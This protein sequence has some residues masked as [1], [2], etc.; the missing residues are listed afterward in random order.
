[1]G[2]PRGWYKTIVAEVAEM[3]FDEDMA[4]AEIAAKLECG[5]HAVYKALRL[6]GRPLRSSGRR[7]AFDETEIALIK[8][9]YLELDWPSQMI[10][11]FFDVSDSTAR[12]ALTDNNVELRWFGYKTK[13][14][15]LPKEQ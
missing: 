15:P 1:M 14:K 11:D 12:R 13:P 9:M 4:V 2:K 6:D 3:Y 5:K 8:K 10:A 7:A